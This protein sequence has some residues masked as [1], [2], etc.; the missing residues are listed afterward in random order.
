MSEENT[1]L[2]STAFRGYDKYQVD[3]MIASLRADLER[4]LAAEASAAEGLRR[5]GFELDAANSRAR[6]AEER[7]ERLAAEIQEIPVAGSEPAEGVSAPRIE[8]EEILRVADEQANTVITNAVEQGEKFVAEAQAEVAKLRADAE[9]E[10][11]SIRQRAE[12]ELAQTQIRIETERTANQARIEQDLASVQDKVEQAEREA[13]AIKSEAE[14]DAA[15]IRQIAEAE[16][17]A[18]RAESERIVAEARAKQLEYETALTRREDQAQQE[19]L[20]LHN[21]AVAHAERIVKDANDKVGRALEHSQRIEERTEAYERSARTQAESVRAAADV[22]AG[23][24]IDGAR[25]RAQAI[26]NTVI[27]HTKDVARDAEDRARA[28]RVQQ[29]TLSSFLTEVGTLVTGLEDYQ[30]GSVAGGVVTDSVPAVDA[31]DTDATDASATAST[32]GMDA[33]VDDT[34]A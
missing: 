22:R 2:F 23:E 19:F 6:E 16:V 31:S 11:A 7:L 8:F 17:A 27:L 4:Q 28:L 15:N 29:Q 26:V 13:A 24:I 21:Q 3:E 9:A 25:T 33:S 30:R 12:H 1:E 32:P 18:I 34:E 5:M 14:R 20:A 10:A